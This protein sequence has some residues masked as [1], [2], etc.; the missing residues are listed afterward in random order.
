MYRMISHYMLQNCLLTEELYHVPQHCGIQSTALL[1]SLFLC[2]SSLLCH[3]FVSC[4]MM[5]FSTKLVPNCTSKPMSHP[6]SSIVVSMRKPDAVCRF[7][8]AKVTVYSIAVSDLSNALCLCIEACLIA[9]LS[10]LSD[11]LM[12]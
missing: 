5:P 12:V 2:I 8:R 9:K 10:R 11:C 6:T 3:K 7:I 4:S 1:T